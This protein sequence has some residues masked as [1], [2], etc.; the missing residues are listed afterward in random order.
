[1]AAS[2]FYGAGRWS[3]DGGV[4]RYAGTRRESYAYR[5]IAKSYE[6]I[7]SEPSLVTRITL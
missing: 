4:H 3:A 6:G 5:I 2:G 7:K 1:M